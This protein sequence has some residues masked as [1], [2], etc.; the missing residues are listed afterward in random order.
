MNASW[1]K[2]NLLLISMCRILHTRLNFSSVSHLRHSNDFFIFIML[3]KWM[4]FLEKSMNQF[5]QPLAKTQIQFHYKLK[6]L[7]FL[8]ST[9]FTHSHMLSITKPKQKYFTHQM[10]SSTGQ[11]IA[12]MWNFDVL[13]CVCVF[14]CH[15]QAKITYVLIYLHLI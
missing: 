1:Q 3:S 8:A 12:C 7:P 4:N 2:A 14:F 5:L 13:V 9:F 10:H 6:V 11:N 15:L